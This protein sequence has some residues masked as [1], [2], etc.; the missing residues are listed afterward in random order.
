MH[1]T[2]FIFDLDDEHPSDHWTTERLKDEFFICLT[3]VKEKIYNEGGKIVTVRKY[4]NQ[5]I[6]KMYLIPIAHP[7]VPFMIDVNDLSSRVRDDFFSYCEETNEKNVTY[8][9]KEV[10]GRFFE[11]LDYEYYHCSIMRVLK[12]R[13]KR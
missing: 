1:L 3:R 9:L 7:S 12:V 8:F 4:Y 6:S 2:K 10:S 5:A 11:N 13:L